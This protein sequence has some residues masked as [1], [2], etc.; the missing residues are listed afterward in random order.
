MAIPARVAILL[1]PSLSYGL[2]SSG[3]SRQPGTCASDF[4]ASLLTGLACKA[5][6]AFVKPPAVSH[7]AQDPERVL[8][9]S[10]SNFFQDFFFKK[11][12]FF[13]FDCGNLAVHKQPRN[14]IHAS[15]ARAG[16][17]VIHR[18]AWVGHRTGG[19]RSTPTAHLCRQ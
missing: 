12:L 15:N 10:F 5:V 17:L 19:S 8:F 9:F 14:T 11:K 7:A 18:P 6:I 13:L 3:T 4:S 2:T 16:A 1:Q